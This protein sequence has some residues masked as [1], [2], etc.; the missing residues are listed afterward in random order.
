MFDYMA[1][2]PHVDL[3]KERADEAFI[4]NAIEQIINA[5]FHVGITSLNSVLLQHFCKDGSGI[6][7]D[8]LKG[9]Y[10][11]ILKE[12]EEELTQNADLYSTIFL[13]MDD[14]FSFDGALSQIPESI[15]PVFKE[16][17]GNLNIAYPKLIRLT[18]LS[19]I[20]I[21]FRDE[22]K[23]LSVRAE[24]KEVK[25]YMKS[26]YNKCIEAV[27]NYNPLEDASCDKNEDDLVSMLFGFD[28]IKDK[29]K[30]EKE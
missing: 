12:F 18:A 23:C 9:C 5:G 1:V 14:T 21:Y 7:R 29:K 16:M 4:D 24:I 3:L 19:C 22:D 13:Q 25:K 17:A 10:D 20:F 8:D 6:A 15:R 30:E 27:A 2:K 28:K 26:A 11:I